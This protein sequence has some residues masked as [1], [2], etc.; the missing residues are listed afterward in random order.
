[1]SSNAQLRAPAEHNHA[2]VPAW[3]DEIGTARILIVDDQPSNIQIVGAVLGNLGC[4]IIPASDGGTALKRIALRKPDLILLDLLMPVMGGCE[5]CR[6][7]KANPDWKDIPV[8]FLSASDD[9]DLIVR[10]LD[11]GGVD[12]ITKPF[13]H[14]ELTSRVRTQLALKSARDQLRQV[15]EDKDELL[16]VLAH[17]LK[18]YLGGINMSAGLLCRQATRLNDPRTMQLAENIQ[19]SSAQ[20]LAF[21]M[22]F[23][24]NIAADHGFALKP[25]NVDLVVVTRAA[26]R[27]YE[28]AA[29]QKRINI[30]TDFPAGAVIVH[31]D[32]SALGQILG[33]LISNAV[34]F[35]PPEKEVFLSIRPVNNRVECIVRDE[36]PGFT[37]ED[38]TRMFRRYGRLSARPTGGEPSTGLG[39]SIVRRLVQ[40]MDGELLCESVAGNGAA[41][42][43]RL[44]GPPPAG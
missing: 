9:K 21:V 34:K 26:A 37:A 4:E 15:A 17:D 6:L 22:A 7:L 2:M 35:S 29:R 16:G 1:M 32:V 42:T 12:F 14:A 13:N 25:A 43:V 39:L 8:I 36:G 20:S 5:V 19:H 11:S 40:A 30:Q 41:F 28:E 24:A 27:Q 38:K 3:S 44:P 23:L 18:N 31:A 10:A 33:N